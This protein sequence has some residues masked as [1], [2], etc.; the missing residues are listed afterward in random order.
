MRISLRLA[1]IVACMFTVCSSSISAYAQGTSVAVLD[2]GLVFKKH[3]RFEQAMEVMKSDVTKFE[4]YLRDERAKVQ[5]MVEGLQGYKNGTK[6]YND[7]EA[8]IAK[9]TSNLQV[10]TKLKQ[11]EFMQREAKLYFNTYEEMQQA[12]NAFATKYN[13]ELV[14]RF[15]SE[16]IQQDNPQTILQGV[17]ASVVYHRKRDI[18]NPIIEMMNSGSGTTIGR[19]PG[20]QIPVKQSR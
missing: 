1:T 11:K 10:E 19:E 14:L 16:D 3:V 8:R 20:P 9:I 18:T 12:V 7:L 5:E 2:V 4:N 17:N 15:N 13:V 6:E